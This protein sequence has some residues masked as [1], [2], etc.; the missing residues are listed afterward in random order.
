MADVV[1]F[2]FGADSSEALSALKQVRDG[3]QNIG[4]GLSVVSLESMLSLFDRLKGAA[5]GLWDAF[6][7]PAAEIEN[8][9]VRF[10]VLLGS[11]EAA[12]AMVKRLTE[13]AAKTPFEMSGIA[14]ATN[15]LLSFGLGADEAVSTL[16]KLGD[17]AAVSGSSL[18][19]LARIYGKVSAVGTMDTEAINMLSERGL[20]M[21]KM[22]A[23]RDGISV[24]EVQKRVERRQYGKAD[25]DY[26]LNKAT[27]EGG[28]YNQGAK[29]MS[30]TFEGMVSTL[31]DN[32]TALGAAIGENFLEPMK[33]GIGQLQAQ[34]PELARLVE[35]IVVP[36]G[37]ITAVMMQHLP[38]ILRL[39]RDIAI[40]FG[41][42][43]LWPKIMVGANA[44]KLV[45][46][47]TA[48]LSRQLVANVKAFGL[49]LGTARTV[50]T[51]LLGIFRA[52]GK[53]GWMLVIT[54]AVEA[55]SYLYDKFFGSD[56]EGADD[57]AQQ[58][59]EALANAKA[60]EKAIAERLETMQQEDAA[61]LKELKARLEEAR[62]IEEVTKAAEELRKEMDALAQ[63]Q[64]NA[65]GW[66]DQRRAEDL[67]HDAVTMN[68]E[69]RRYEAEARRRQAED[70][71]KQRE[72][73][74][75]WQ[76]FD[77]QHSRNKEQWQAQYNTLSAQQQR[78]LIRAFIGGGTDISDAAIERDLSAYMANAQKAGDSTLFESAKE[79]YK[80]FDAVRSREAK[81]REEYES[82][83][84]EKSA[85]LQ[86]INDREAWLQ[87]KLAKDEY[88]AWRLENAIAAQALANE[89]MGYGL[90]PEDAQKRA[91]SIRAQEEQ[92]NA[93]ENSTRRQWV[94]DSLQRIGGGGIGHSLGEAQLTVSRQQLTVAEQSRDILADI[95][96]RMGVSAIPVVP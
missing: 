31:K 62:S 68:A 2:K 26:V 57:R 96:A 45:M 3:V 78:Q 5:S 29:K 36:L 46:A 65:V 61:K 37:H 77:F 20:N 75:Y 24:A 25:M 69:M 22:L 59:Q 41:V 21:R 55:L 32:F 82:E 9:N 17:M 90:S 73:E 11:A 33:E 27:G 56:N 84:K 64:K 67:L 49:G 34:L 85:G 53:V 51:G 44:F 10:E 91:A 35:P 93:A 88:N 83:Q 79:Y 48:A 50:A 8:Y 58:R 12:A 28:Q 38:L 60:E 71:R 30:G 13:Y 72:N 80:L 89:L 66:E 18:E 43:M 94:T 14:S 87:A 7:A 39:M 63:K 40:S 54:A 74:L 81:E 70:A 15:T 86:Q 95:Q 42:L 1:N 76:S 92:L 6:L 47:S 4:K 16:K 19:D 52:I 23:E